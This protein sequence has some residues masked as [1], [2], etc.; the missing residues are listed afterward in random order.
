[1][2]KTVSKRP[3][4][5]KTENTMLAALVRQIKIL[6]KTI[7]DLR[8]A[9]K[10]AEV[11]SGPPKS[12]AEAIDEYESYLAAVKGL[13]PKTIA[14]YVYDLG[15]FRSFMEES[16]GP[17][18]TVQQIRPETISGFLEKLHRRGCGAITTTRALSSIRGF[19]AYGVRIGHLAVSPARGF[20]NPKRPY[21]LPVYLTEDELDRLLSIPDMG[22]W[23][24]RRDAAM[25]AAFAFGGLRLQELINLGVDDVDFVNR[26]M[27]I[28]GKGRKQRPIPLNQG[29][30][31]AL[32]KYLE[33]RPGGKT[34]SLFISYLLKTLSP[35]G[36]EKALAKHARKAGIAA[37]KGH[38]HALRH[39]FGTGLHRRGVDIV[40]IRSLMGHGSVATTQ[41]YV[42]VNAEELRDAVGKLDAGVDG[43]A[44][45]KGLDQ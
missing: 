4:E 21:N 37:I 25:L 42:S 12:L 45:G 6:T 38:P 27:L 3:G 14:A 30:S 41:I 31:D 39:S 43:G 15:R 1:M 13:S 28:N 34:G 18:P 44:R 2:R 16:G 35:R 8:A 17:A 10:G 40:E 33:V 23:L 5:G 20:A 32:Q 7:E 26:T 36:V 24:G 19:L 11:E 29:L 9:G 22:T